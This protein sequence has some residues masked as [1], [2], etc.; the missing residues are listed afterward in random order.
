MTNRCASDGG[1]YVEKDPSIPPDTHNLDI[2]RFGT[3]YHGLYGH[4]K[5]RNIPSPRQH[6]NPLSPSHKNTSDPLPGR[7][8]SIKFCIVGKEGNVTEGGTKSEE[9]DR[10]E[11]QGRA[12]GSREQGPYRTYRTY[13]TGTYRTYKTYK[14]YWSYVS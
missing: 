14:T 4:V 3:G 13:K 9:N 10:G 7:S 8:F 6:G 5:P 12:T 11:R 1:F 2:L